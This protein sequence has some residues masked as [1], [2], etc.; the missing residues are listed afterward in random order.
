M[1]FNK[2]LKYKNKYLKTKFFMQNGG[3]RGKCSVCTKSTYN[4]C[5]KCKYISYCS[6]ECQKKD[7]E[8]HKCI[9]S[10]NPGEI[11]IRYKAANAIKNF[12]QII[13]IKFDYS[14]TSQNY[15]YEYN[16]P[17]WYRAPL[18][19]DITGIR[20]LEIEPN[21]YD[22]IRL[23][24]VPLFNYSLNEI[25]NFNTI[26]TGRD[27]TPIMDCTNAFG[28]TMFAILNAVIPEYINKLLNISIIDKIIDKSPKIKLNMFGYNR[29]IEINTIKSYINSKKLLEK[30]YN[31][32]N[33]ILLNENKS[34]RLYIIYF[35]KNL[36]FKNKLDKIKL[37]DGCYIHG[38]SKYKSTMGSYV[39]E[40]VYCVDFT[41]VGKP[42]F[43]GF[44]GNRRNIQDN[45]DFTNPQELGTIQRFLAI[46]Y[47]K[48]VN[49]E[50]TEKNIQM[51]LQDVSSRNV[52]IQAGLIIDNLKKIPLDISSLSITN[53]SLEDIENQQS[54]ITNE[55]LL[56][57][58]NESL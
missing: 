53:V 22:I 15:M 12:Y 52:V 1:Y 2:Y 46:E 9:C 27:P 31:E 47:L 41:S 3:E 20:N 13:N 29:N 7:W 48:A 5:S 10:N 44:S 58:L 37:G 55:D 21:Y 39:G 25:L 19:H 54:D 24:P 16:Y 57:K 6:K 17:G 4:L 18:P 28:M 56:R 36:F 30:D 8:K 33:N 14:D 35:I 34:K 26:E 51:A 45:L 49:T 38:H 32:L 40:N 50:L 11:E 43:I 42:L 23:Y